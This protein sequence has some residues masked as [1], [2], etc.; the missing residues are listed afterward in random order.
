MGQIMS[1]K[2]WIENKVN[3][4]LGT[5]P[6]V[7]SAARDAHVMKYIGACDVAKYI[8]LVGPKVFVEHVR[9]L[10]KE[11]KHKKSIE[12]HETINAEHEVLQIEEC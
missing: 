7:G 9:F 10:L 3:E 8:E 11:I 6:P 2:D 1:N 12:L 5:W 4:C